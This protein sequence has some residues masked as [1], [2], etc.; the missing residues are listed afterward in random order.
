MKNSILYRSAGAALITI[1]LL[2][3]NTVDISKAE[4]NDVQLRISGGYN[5]ASAQILNHMNESI[6]CSFTVTFEKFGFMGTK[7]DMINDTV[8]ENSQ[9]ILTIG[10]QYRFCRIYATLSVGDETLAT[11]GIIFFGFVFFNSVHTGSQW[12]P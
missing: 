9:L 6:N 3:L 2:S 5:C 8:S 12:I 7:F 4:E 10:N 11:E 1:L